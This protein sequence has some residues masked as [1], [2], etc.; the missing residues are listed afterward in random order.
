MSVACLSVS[1]PLS[2]LSKIHEVLTQL[3]AQGVPLE[4]SS[5]KFLT[6]KQKSSTKASPGSSLNKGKRIGTTSQQGTTPSSSAGKKVFDELPETKLGKRTY[7]QAFP[8]TCHQYDDDD[9][10]DL[11]S[12]AS[13]DDDSAVDFDLDECKD[14]DANFSDDD[15]PSAASAPAA[16]AMDASSNVA[17]ASA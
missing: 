5:L 2:A 15:E 4:L 13:S 12:E 16:V 3:I 6:P 9:E 11:D 1:A 14:D 10:S 8:E 7:S 17:E